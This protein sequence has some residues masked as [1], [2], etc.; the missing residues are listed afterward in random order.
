MFRAIKVRYLSRC[1]LVEDRKELFKL[2]S[3]YSTIGLE[4]G[5]SVFIGL[6]IGIYLDKFLKTPPWM[7][8]IFLF[9]GIIAAFRVI[10]R[11]AKEDKQED[12]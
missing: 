12:S 10:L 4:M 5:F 7:T 2:V 8:I 6:L 11:I 9:Y 1:I 3:R